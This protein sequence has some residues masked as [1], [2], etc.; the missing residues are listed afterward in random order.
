[1]PGEA[2]A[3]PRGGAGPVGRIE[4]ER[5]HALRRALTDLLSRIAGRREE[6]GSPTVDRPDAE[7]VYATKA[8]RKFVARVTSREGASLLDLGPVVGGNVAFFGE[9]GVKVYVEDL[10]ADLDVLARR[11]ADRDLAQYWRTRLRHDD[12]VF[13][14]VICWDLIDYLDRPVAQVLARELMRVLRPDGALLGFFGTTDTIN[15]HYTK[16]IIVDEANL[17][18]R[19]LP[20]VRAKRHVLQ[21][22]DII[23]LFGSLRVSDSYLLHSHLREILF[24]KPETVAARP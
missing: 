23:K 8:L 2:A 7:P 6:I 18:H 9:R 24:R 11:G 5:P 3:L 19:P 12:A 4:P 17:R 15:A 20:G 14:G 10:Y 1:M 16:Y 21:N 13:D 22:R